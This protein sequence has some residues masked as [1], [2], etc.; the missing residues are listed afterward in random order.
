MT[1]PIAVAMG[2]SQI[3]LNILCPLYNLYQDYLTLPRVEYDK[4]SAFLYQKSVSQKRMVLTQTYSWDQVTFSLN[5]DHT[6]RM[7]FCF[8]HTKVRQS[9]RL[10]YRFRIDH[11]ST[12]PPSTN[13][14][15]RN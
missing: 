12:A 13:I 14:P 7:C 6:Q 8:L 3:V 10:P 1:V 11:L 9:K 5:L 15:L 2:N 4:E